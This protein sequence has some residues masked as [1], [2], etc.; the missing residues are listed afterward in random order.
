MTQAKLAKKLKCTQG[1]ISKLYNGYGKPS[2]EMA[3]RW[4]K[5]TGW[6]YNKWRKATVSQIQRMMDSIGG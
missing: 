6:G 4:K 1:Y 2:F 5:L 3:E